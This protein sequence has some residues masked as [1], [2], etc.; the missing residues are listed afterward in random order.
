MM[1]NQKLRSTMLA[2]CLVVMSC[3]TALAVAPEGAGNREGVYTFTSD[4]FSQN[5]P[6]WVQALGE[7]KG[8]PNLRYLEI[9]VYEG[10]SFF[11]VMDNILTDPSSRATAIDTFDIYL[12]NDPEVAFRNNLRRSG[13]EPKV[14]VIKGTSREKLRELPLHSFDLIYVDGDHGSKS[15]LVDAVLSWDL[16]KEGGLII[17]DDYDWAHPIPMEMRPAFALDVFQT[18]MRDEFQVV[19]KDYQLIIRNAPSACDKSHGFVENVASRLDCSPLGQYVYY[20]KPRKL[21]DASDGNRGIVLSEKEISM[22][23]ETLKNRKLGFKLEVENTGEYTELLNRLKL[24]D[25]CAW[26]KLK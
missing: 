1:L 25:I 17:F 22:I 26:P 7:L 3:G 15:V 4:W 19:V 10:R 11:W 24:D 21:F 20:W 16:L 9:G 23:E 14:T 6:I 5:I 18:L 13:H 8:K 2:W 12:D